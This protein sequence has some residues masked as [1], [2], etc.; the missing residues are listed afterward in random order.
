[1]AICLQICYLLIGGVPSVMLAS[2]NRTQKQKKFKL[3][4]NM[5]LV[6]LLQQAI[7]NRLKQKGICFRLHFTWSNSFDNYSTKRYF[8][9]NLFQQYDWSS[10]EKNSVYG[11]FFPS[12]FQKINSCLDRVRSIQNCSSFYRFVLK[13]CLILKDFFFLNFSDIKSRFSI[14]DKI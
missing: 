4:A 3:P 11:D 8:H 1:M 2:I 9:D 13:I 12:K 6:H 14:S 10:K 5:K 7:R